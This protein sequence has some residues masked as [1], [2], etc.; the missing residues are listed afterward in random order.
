ME[1]D[2]SPWLIVL[3][4]VSPVPLPMLVI[5]SIPEGGIPKSPTPL[6]SSVPPLSSLSVRHVFCGSVFTCI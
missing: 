1:S 3:L 5:L 4:S 2:G 6:V